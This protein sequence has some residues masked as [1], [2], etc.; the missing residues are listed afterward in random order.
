MPLSVRPPLITL[1]LIAALAPVAVLAEQSPAPPPSAQGD[2]I[3][4]VQ[5]VYASKTENKV[6]PSLQ[7]IHKRLAQLFDFTFYRLESARR[8]QGALGREGRVDLPDGKTLLLKPV[9][10]KDD[11][12]KVA[13]EIPKL[14]KTD[15]LIK[16][17]NMVI[18]GG[19][20][21]DQGVLILVI[22]VNPA[23]KR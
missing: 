13:V 2:L 17:G 8:I 9:E 6:D 12:W 1:I 23:A 15:L 3:I 22:E 18:I 4:N 5:V 21:Y 11:M 16:D 10:K 19:T 20:K 7:G 14:I